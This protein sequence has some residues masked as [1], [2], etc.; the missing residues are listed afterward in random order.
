M[1]TVKFAG[2]GGRGVVTPEAVEPHPD[3]A[4]AAPAKIA[5][6]HLHIST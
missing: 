1:Y 3:T 4:R 5:I 2:A 6:V